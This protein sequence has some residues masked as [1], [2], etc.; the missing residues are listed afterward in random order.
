MEPKEAIQLFL[1]QYNGNDFCT[2]CIKCKVVTHGTT[3]D[4]ILALVNHG[5]SIEGEHALFFYKHV[6]QQLTSA[7]QLNIQKVL[8]LKGDFRYS[9]SPQAKF[10]QRATMVT[11]DE[12]L[13]VDIV[14]DNKAVDF[15]SKLK[16]C[17][18]ASDISQDFR[19][20]EQYQIRNQPD[21]H[22]QVVDA[23]GMAPFIADEDRHGEETNILT[24]Q[25]NHN[26][27]TSQPPKR[28]P[29]PLYSPNRTALPSSSSPKI[30]PAC[31]TNPPPRPPP[32]HDNSSKMPPFITR[33]PPKTNSAHQTDLSKMTYPSP[34]TSS[35]S[36]FY[37]D[38][39]ATSIVTRVQI[40][41]EVLQK[42]END[43][44]YLQPFRLFIG[45]FNVNGKNA[46]KDLTTWLHCDDTKEPAHMYAIGFQE[47]DLSP[48]AFLFNTSDRE[49]EWRIAVEHVL[50]NLGKYKLVEQVRLVGIMLLVYVTEDH[51]ENVTENISETVA[52]G[53]MGTMGNKGGVGVRLKFHKTTFCFINSHLAA[54]EDECDRRNQDYN[55][56]CN[57]IKFE[58]ETGKAYPIRSHDLVIWMGDLN[59]RITQLNRETV[60]EKINSREY[61]SLLENDQL[62]EQIQLGKVLKHYVEGGIDF[63]PTY[64]FD[65]GTDNYDTSPKQKI[66]SWCDRIFYLGRN[67]KQLVY[68]SHNLITL[69][70]HKPVSSLFEVQVKVVD[71]A[72]YR[73][74]LEEET[75][76][77]DR[78]VNESLPRLTISTN[79]IKIGT[80][81]F[82]ERKQFILDVA[83]TGQAHTGFYF[84]KTLGKE[85]F[86]APWVEVEPAQKFL[87]MGDN[88]EVEIHIEVNK[89]T[90]AALNRGDRTLDAT[91]ILRLDNETDYY[92]DLRGSYQPS[93][94]GS[95][96]ET[97]VRMLEPMRNNDV[98]KIMEME[99][100]DWSKEA[101]SNHSSEKLDCPKEIK[102]MLSHLRN[103]GRDQEDLFRR[104]GIHTEFQA[105]RDALDTGAQVLPGSIFSVAEALLLFLESLSVPVIPFMYYH[106]CL[107]FN[108][109]T[110]C[111]K[112]VLEKIPRS[113]RSV[114]THLIIFM[115]EML[116]RHDDANQID[117]DTLA[118][119]FGERCLRTPPEEM[120]KEWK[121]KS[122]S[123]RTV[124]GQDRSR[125]K[126]HFMYHFTV[127]K[128]L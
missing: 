118:S 117:G 13:E 95:S 104:G 41:D 81:R 52:T 19:W 121:D 28:P 6:Q 24:V 108:R 78:E 80:V 34:H 27:S 26:K 74:V 31:P 23:F 25:N 32:F 107:E 15:F 125:K 88:V 67:C 69:S 106:D 58:M 93:C 73:Q 21:K 86:L 17:M 65:I 36:N 39:K 50:Q 37:I 127:T 113:H 66:P 72:K 33:N 120:E 62:L 54:H 48:G 115:K 16:D 75:R 119:L 124:I 59:Y 10:V 49:K 55:D 110:S 112:Q 2:A 40:R 1:S 43:F 51:K 57:G 12:T 71:E 42:R 105:I 100:T 35:T 47:L 123:K 98:T 29:R 114:L 20:I 103:H 14:Y 116:P 92:I 111:C 102:K 70:D 46:T 38:E 79:E 4:H 61:R 83:N 84:C 109:N 18:S 7:H 87:V 22:V 44:T 85:C 97:L 90:A 9:L 5:A 101:K 126:A 64:K 56:I 77:L 99:K 122:N 11:T 63:K 60:F 96:I 45:T 82:M 94:F 8:K 128:H 76:N 30:K 53:I 68:R 3:G 91:L 89:S